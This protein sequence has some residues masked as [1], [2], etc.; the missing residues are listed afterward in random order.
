MPRAKANGIELEYDTFGD[1]A[2]PPLILVMGFSMQLIAWDERFCRELAS[3]GFHVVRFDNRDVGLSTKLD[4]A[5]VPDIAR[6]MGGDASIAPYAIEDM[7]DDLAGLLDAMGFERAH[8]V[9]VS[10]GGFISQAAAIRH[11]GRVSSLAS[12]MSSTGDR[13]VGHAK[14]EILGA[15]M[16]PPPTNRDEAMDRSALMWR[17]IGSPGFPFDEAKA[18]ER[19]SS[20]WDRNHEPLG[21]MRQMAA[22]LTQRD[23]TTDLGRVRVPTVVIHGADDPLIHVSGGE[24]TARAIA[25]ARLVVVPG[26]GHDLPEGA[27]PTIIGAI[28]DNARRAS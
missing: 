25:D 5:G 26:M 7:A 15:F 17:L 27:W 21:V 18:R 4:A 23:R 9:G 10:M 14:G 2:K 13:S 16:A 20:A 24:A 1:P 22:I 6:A 12:I 28:A 8:L 11:P 19:G 3:R